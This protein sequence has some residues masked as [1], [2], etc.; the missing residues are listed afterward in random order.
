MSATHNRSGA[1]R[2]EVPQRQVP[3]P[4]RGRVGDRGPLD[5]AAAGTDQTQ[6]AHQPLHGAPGHRD[7]FPVQLQ[8]HLPRAVDP[9]V[10]LVDP[11]DLRFQVLV[12]DAR[13]GW[14]AAPTA[15]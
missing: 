7:A 5:L 14:A 8:P 2:P 15:S 3:G 12:A 9:E 6:V 13:C 1:E 11:A 10:L 4:L